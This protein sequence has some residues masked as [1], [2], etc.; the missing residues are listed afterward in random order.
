MAFLNPLAV[1][2]L[3]TASS[4][5]LLALASLSAW[6]KKNVIGF[7]IPLFALGIFDF[8]NGL[9]LEF[10]APLPGPYN[11]LFGDSVLFLGLLLIIGGYMLYKKIDLM[12]VSPVAALFGIYLLVDSYAVWTFNLT[13][14]P[15]L[16]AAMFAGAGL[17]AVTQLAASKDRDYMYLV[18][19]ALLALVALALLFFTYEA[20][21][22]H[23]AG[24]VAA[25]AG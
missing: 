20:I 25:A 19:G 6:K 2:I 18:C 15:M 11:L 10:M 16:T 3:G 12:Y 5:T 1:I 23:I 14:T 22:G 21:F 17:A 9:F 4:A 13:R 7:S 8:I 24:F